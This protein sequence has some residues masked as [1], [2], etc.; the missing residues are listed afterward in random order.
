MRDHMRHWLTCSIMVFVLCGC[1]PSEH[2]ETQP[3]QKEVQLEQT[4]TQGEQKEAQPEQTETQAPRPTQLTISF[5]TSNPGGKYKPKNSHVI[6]VET[7]DGAYVKTLD[8]WAKKQAKHLT[9]WAAAAGDIKNE[10]AARTGATQKTH[11][12]Y[13]SLWD[14]KDAAGN[15]VPDGEYVI[16]L[17]L[18]SDNA[19]KNKYH[20]TSIP[21]TKSEAAEKTEPVNQDGYLKIVLDYSSSAN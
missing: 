20:R 9:Q 6:W 12:A 14:L 10:V 8:L 19:N 21:F 11:G 1:E 2:K 17:E 15:V 5:E 7:A 18:T 4:V 16:R 3:E 13:Q